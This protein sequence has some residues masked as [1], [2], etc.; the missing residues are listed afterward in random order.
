MPFEPLYNIRMPPKAPP[1]YISIQAANSLTGKLPYLQDR[2]AFYHAA[3]FSPVLSTWTHAISAGYL[4]SWP[5]LTTKPVTQYAP[6]SEARSLGHMHAQRSN[7]RSTKDTAIVTNTQ[8][9]S[10]RTNNI[11]ADCR[12]ITGNIR[13]DQTGRFIVPSTSSNN[14]LFILYDYDS[15]SIQAEPIPNRKKESI[16][17]AYEK[18]LRLLQRRGLHPQLH[19]LDNEASQLLKEFVTNEDIEFQLAPASLHRRNWAERAIQPF[20]NHFIS[21]LCTTHPDFPLNLWD[22]LLPQVILTLNLLRPS[23]INPQ[24]SA[25]AQVHGNFNYDK[26]PLAP[27]PGIKVLAHEPA[28]GRESFAVHATRGYYVGPC[29]HHYR[30]FTIWTPSV[31][32]NLF[33]RSPHCCF[34]T[35]A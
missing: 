24:L 35:I 3:L 12:A 16:K 23:R 15:N 18:I 1:S 19:R 2:I 29:L 25:H 9:S 20:K 8:A 5:A 14:Y 31:E 26:T 28:G 30:C 13:S 27:P 22:K 34:V 10:Q 7:I 11:Y 33:V 32:R 21:G 6:R 4:D 17:A